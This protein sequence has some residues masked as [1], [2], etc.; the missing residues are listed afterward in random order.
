MEIIKQRPIVTALAIVG[1]LMLA[2]TLFYPFGYDQAVFGVGGEMILHGKIPYRDFLD[3]KQ[4][5]IFYLYAVA[6][7]VFGR[8][9]WSIHLFDIFYQLFAAYY[10]FRILRR[11]LSF[12]ISLLAVSLTLILYAGSGFWMTCEAESFA[13]LPALLLVDMTQ[14]TVTSKRLAKAQFAL[15]YGLLAGVAAIS[16]V[17]L[18]FTLVLGAFASMVF[19]L[20]R[21][22]IN[23][24]IKWRYSIAPTASS[25]ALALTCWLALMW[26]GA[27]H[28]FLQSLGWLWHYGAIGNP[29]SSIFERLFLVFPE[30]LVYSSSIALFVL[31]IIGI[32]LFLKKRNSSPPKP[33]LILLLYTGVFQLVGVLAERKIEFPYQ[34][35]RA[36]WAFTP[37]M[38][39]GLIALLQTLELLWKSGGVPRR[40]V[41]VVGVACVLWL[42]P[43]A[44]IFSQTIPWAAIAFSEKDASA[45]VQRRIPDYFPAEQH[46]A[47]DY[48]A[49]RVAPNDQ[50]FFWGND[51]GIYFFSNTL[52]QTICLTATPL[53]TSFTPPEWK[54]TLLAQLSSAPPKYIV[55]EF[56]DAKPYITGSPLDSYQSLLAWDGLESF[57]AS[58]YVRDTTIGHFLIFRRTR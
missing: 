47:A 17:L 45:E 42:S 41:W 56:G 4:P 35:T 26:A 12:E 58:K 31:G 43:L 54:A 32:V 34:Y 10:F 15:E 49:S 18:K 46:E 29:S 3:T 38:A 23:G 16:L 40:A 30:R 51:V 33:L 44:R 28:P 48:L 22:G 52:P 57:L 7:G 9:E 11:E 19:V 24:K 20:S 27:L 53:R 6:I 37:F 8:H 36:L 55:A 39:M 50:I 5:L 1:G 14:R 13:I 25:I 2:A 21:P